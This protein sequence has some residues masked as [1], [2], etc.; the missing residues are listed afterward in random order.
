MDQTGCPTIE[1]LDWLLAGDLPA[2]ER[3]RVSAH[4][5][6]CSGCLERVDELARDV[7]ATVVRLDAYRGCA[8]AGPFYAKCGYALLFVGTFDLEYFERAVA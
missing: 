6:D 2:G 8:G 3:D 7:N 5:D 4:L 1:R